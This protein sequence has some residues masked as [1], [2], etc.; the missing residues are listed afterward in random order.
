MAGG[1]RGGDGHGE[2]ENERVHDEHQPDASG[3]RG[4]REGAPE[5]E[6]G[7]ER[8]D[9]GTGFEKRAAGQPN[10]MEKSAKR[11]IAAP[12]MSRGT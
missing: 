1:E 8:E 11:L 2:E 10:E 3:G 9:E 4:G 6:K 5:E 7:G 12:P